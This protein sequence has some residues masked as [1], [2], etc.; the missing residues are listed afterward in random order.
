MNKY[1]GK[2]I[3]LILLLVPVAVYFLWKSAE[4]GYTPLEVIGIEELDGSITPFTIGEFELV[5][6]DSQIVNQD[7]FEDKIMV[8]NFFY[9][10][11]PSICPRMN[12]ALRLVVHKF[13]DRDDL[14]FV[15]HTV[16][17]EH[18]S[19]HILK[20]YAAKYGY[21]T[22]KWQFLTGSRSVLYDLGVNQYHVNKTERID[23]NDFLHSTIVVLVDPDKRIRGYFEANENPKFVNELSDAIK[24]LRREY[25]D[26]KHE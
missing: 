12:N 1:R 24:V 11:C 8:A 26:K 2:I 5:N 20:E 19:V 9:A 6:Q 22:S 14:V 16:N 4:T 18:D 23:E 10:T 21:P 17:P 3:I 7:S 13:K 25:Y 15:S